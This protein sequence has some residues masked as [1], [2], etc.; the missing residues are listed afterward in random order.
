MRQLEDIYYLDILLEKKIDRFLPMIQKYP[1]LRDNLGLREFIQSAIDTLKK[2]DRIVWFLTWLRLISLINYQSAFIAEAEALA[3]RTGK[4]T[5]QIISSVKEYSPHHILRKLDHYFSLHIPEIDNKVFSIKDTPY[6]ID[7]FEQIEKKYYEQFAG[8]ISQ[9]GNDEIIIKFA[10]GWVWVNNH[11]PTCSA[12]ERKA[13]QHC[14]NEYGH[15]EEGDEIFSLREPVT[16]GNR[17]AWRPHLTFVVNNGTIREAKGKQN[18]KP[19]DKYHPYIVELLKSNYIDKIDCSGSYAPQNN[20]SLNDLDE[21]T[22]QEIFELKGDDFEN[23]EQAQIEKKLKE[24]DEYYKQHLKHSYVSY[25]DSGEGFFYSDGS[26]TFDFDNLEFTD[27]WNKL[28][29]Q[30]RHQ[31]T[32]DINKILHIYGDVE[33][34][35][36]RLYVQLRP[37]ESYTDAAE[38]MEQI[39]DTLIA[40]EKGEYNDDFNEII[41]YFISHGYV[42][43][44]KAQELLQTIEDEFD[45][46]S[47]D[48]FT[49]GNIEISF[50][51]DN[52]SSTDNANAKKDEITNYFIKTSIFD[53]LIKRDVK[54]RTPD[55]K[56][57]KFKLNESSN[58]EHIIDD[59]EFSVSNYGKIFI[60]FKILK[61][62]EMNDKAIQKLTIILNYIEENYEELGKELKTILR[63]L[64]GE[65]DKGSF[66]S[67]EKFRD[68]YK[69]QLFK[70]K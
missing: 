41:K 13:M 26:C 38:Q 5:E 23:D 70:V 2:D 12:S 62:H 28:K 55:T 66:E 30:D 4:T 7:D 29:Y 3:R 31:I 6:I 21:K 33:L 50:K 68:W 69:K 16:I 49:E 53:K 43:A 25:D 48:D 45:H 60:K 51:Y 17:T 54:F 63:H 20:F 52:P 19:V 56:Q 11:S 18:A 15:K 39:G 35:E 8:T 57:L 36:Q 32:K 40:Y 1:Q 42:R 14:G 67:K 59:V 22:K 37:E 9:E 58:L 10:D 24:L 61:I 47:L 64:L 44:T 27:K 65:A 46:V 34:D